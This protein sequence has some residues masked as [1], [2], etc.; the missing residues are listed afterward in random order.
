MLTLEPS[1]LSNCQLLNVM[2]MVFVIGKVVKTVVMVMV[3]MVMVVRVV[4]VMRVVMVRVV[5][6]PSQVE[7]LGLSGKA[8]AAAEASYHAPHPHRHPRPQQAYSRLANWESFCAECH[9][10]LRCVYP[11]CECCEGTF[12]A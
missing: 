1:V 12:Q 6:M 5:R 10:N 9:S 8:E 4:M 11:G 3:M 7:L 2:V